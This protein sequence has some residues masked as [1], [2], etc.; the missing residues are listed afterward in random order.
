[1]QL[2]VLDVAGRTRELDW[3]PGQSSPD[4]SFE[5]LETALQL[6]VLGGAL[7]NDAQLVT[8]PQ[9]PGDYLV[10]GDPTEGA[11]V[12]AAANLG[13]TKPMLEVT[14]PRVGEVPFSSERKRMSTIHQFGPQAKLYLPLLA[15]IGA[16]QL[17]AR[18]TFT[19][20]AVD[21]ML[22]IC[23][24][25]YVDNQVVALD[26]DWRERIEGTSETMAASALFIVISIK[27]RTRFL[28]KV[29]NLQTKEERE[30][31]S[32]IMQQGNNN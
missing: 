15:S 5:M 24:R 22:E 10:L 18:L 28:F 30:R 11:L 21:A 25:V 7:N 13:L 12:S 23:D 14:F 32:D 9:S 17:H 19:K 16:G 20:G 3:L 6:L 29:L 31:D 2:K 26:S 27:L 4:L 8:D 1:M